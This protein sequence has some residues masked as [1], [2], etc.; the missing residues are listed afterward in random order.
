MEGV[1]RCVEPCNLRPSALLTQ[2]WQGPKRWSV[3]EA[4]KAV[5]ELFTTLP[6]RDASSLHNHTFEMRLYFILALYLSETERARDV[7]KIADKSELDTYQFMDVSQFYEA[8]S[9]SINNPPIQ[10]SMRESWIAL[11]HQLK[12]CTIQSRQ[13]TVAEVEAK[14][15]FLPTDVKETAL[16]ADGFLGG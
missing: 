16:I 4:F 10:S 6:P 3:R 14:L 12:S 5:D 9:A 7:L 15:G 11:N 8:L 13:K 2:R 1:S